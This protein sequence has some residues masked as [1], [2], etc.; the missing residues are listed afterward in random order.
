[1]RILLVSSYGL[2][3]IGG[4]E[5]IVHGYANELGRRGHEV[6]SVF[7]RP[8]PSRGTAGEPEREY[9]DVQVAAL[10][11]L[12]WAFH[13]P[14]PVFS[15]RLLSILAREIRE[16]DVIH[17][18]GFLYMDSVLA[19]AQG[20][21]VGRR[22][23][24]R[25]VRILTEH[26]GFVPY[27]SRPVA[28]LQ[29]GAIAS[30]G[31]LATRSA[32]AI[33][34]YND[35]VADE[36]RRIAGRVPVTFIPNGIDVSQFRPPSGGEREALR[37]E[38]GWDDTPRA[39]FVG[40]LVQ[41]KGVDEVVAAAAEG[42]GRF[43]AV[44]VG[45]GNRGR[46]SGRPNVDVL[47]PRPREEVARLYRAADCLLLPSFG[48][49]FPVVAQ[50]ALSSG[51]P[52]ILRAARDYDSYRGYGSDGLMLISGDA[53]AFARTVER[54]VGNPTERAHRSRAARDLAHEAFS[55][56]ACVERHLELYRHAGNGFRP[57]WAA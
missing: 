39:L 45:P 49:G 9:R 31:R 43:R 26:V 32:D 1:M 3:H 57:E 20:R 12:E 11:H 35:R 15:P 50:E 28:G 52:V 51:L 42:D 25:P 33:V 54:V 38:L 47:G 24:R 30:I 5:G 19:L 55:W 8:D 46:L 4:I 13:V 41:K 7:A 40:R 22:T 6:V 2:P 17:A 27:E 37:Q 29:R 23:S 48:E 18:H 10:N 21:L 44:L 53:A 36:I 34:V 56:D 14:Y 16:A